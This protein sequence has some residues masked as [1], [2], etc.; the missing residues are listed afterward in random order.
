MD[1]FC[2]YGVGSCD[3][4]FVVL[5]IACYYLLT[6]GAYLCKLCPY[7]LGHFLGFLLGVC[8]R[9]FLLLD[10]PLGVADLFFKFHQFLLQE[11]E[12]L[13]ALGDVSLSVQSCLLLVEQFALLSNVSFQRD[14]RMT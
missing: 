13:C 4:H 2:A 12:S 6:Q 11:V 3:D 1:G 9:G 7:L 8:N 10:Q 14:L 5:V